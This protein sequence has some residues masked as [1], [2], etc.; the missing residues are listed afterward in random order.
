MSEK[1]ICLKLL[2]DLS[3]L[4]LLYTNPRDRR[5]RGEF[6]RKTE[7]LNYQDTNPSN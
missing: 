5:F 7:L 2:Q 6:H 1:I 4:S 3:I